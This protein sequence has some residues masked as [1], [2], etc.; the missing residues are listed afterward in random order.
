ML[1]Q[2]S[3]K[4]RKNL[5]QRIRALRQSKGWS[6]ELLARKGNLS[7]SSISAIERG[8]L[9][10]TIKTLCKLSDAFEMKLA[11]LVRDVDDIRE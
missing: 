9:D 7:P 6:Q 2:K 1:V 11:D 5:G 3:A 4:V 8:E 10:L